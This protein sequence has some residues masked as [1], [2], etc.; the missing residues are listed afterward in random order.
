MKAADPILALRRRLGP[1]EV[2][3]LEAPSMVEAHRAL[4]ALLKKPALSAIKQRIARVAPAPLE[5]QLSSIRDGRVFLERRAARATTPAAVRAGLIEY[6]ECLTAWGQA[7]GLDRCARPLVAGGQPVS[8]DEL[9]LW[10]QDDNTGC[11]TGMLR[12]E[13]GSVLLW[14]TEEDTIGYFDR[15]RIASFAIVGG[16]PLFAFLYPYLIPGPAF[17]FSA[18]QVHAV[19]SLHVQRA[20]T[21]A[22]ALT[23]AASWL[24]WRLDGA[25][26]TRAITRAL[27]PFVD[28]CAINVARAS[29]RDVAAE[30]VEIG[31]R[32]ALRRRLHA[33]VGSLVFQANAVSRPQSLLA[34]EE[35]LRARERGPY[36]RRTERTLQAIARLRADRSDPGP[37]DVL[38]L[39]SSRQGG[40]YA[41]ANRDVMAHCVAHIGAT[42]IALYAQSGPAHPTDV[43]SPQWRWP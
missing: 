14:H 4:G 32:R 42:G 33:R 25:V 36:E 21:P 30:N 16:A 15:P 12:R 19:D 10:A 31:G 9:A 29:G 11:Q 43:Y 26:D 17:G 39:M 41:Y 34:T 20:N 6:L 35:A 37:Q 7:I 18:R 24:V 8:A 22:G 27:S 40:S 3:A 13:D 23:S 38:K 5:R 1:I 28:G 2:L